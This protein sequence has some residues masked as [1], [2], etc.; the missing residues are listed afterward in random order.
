[1]KR[2][3]LIALLT[4]LLLG[5]GSGERERGKNSQLD[6]PKPASNSKE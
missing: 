4:G 1:M 2:L 6:R 5:C 3:L